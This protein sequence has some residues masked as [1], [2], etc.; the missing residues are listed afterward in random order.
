MGFEVSDLASAERL[1]D[2]FFAT[3]GSACCDIS[4]SSII[5]GQGLKP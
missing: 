5:F 2:P 3:D 4:A 1:R